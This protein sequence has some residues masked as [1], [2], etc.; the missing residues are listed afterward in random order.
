ML[1][2]PGA[3]AQASLARKGATARDPA[4]RAEVKAAA[5]ALRADHDALRPALD[6]LGARVIGDV[7]LVANA[8]LVRVD[9][10]AL[11]A[12]RKLPGVAR[13]EVPTRV[14]RALA[15]AVPLIGAP[16]VWVSAGDT[17]HT[18]A[19]VRVGV[20]DSG[21]DYYHASLGGSGDPADYAADDATIVEAGTFP[22]AR[23]VGGV[24]LA[25][26]DYDADGLDGSPTPAP[27][28]DPLDCDGH[29]TLVA[30]AAAGGGVLATGLGYAGPWTMSLVPDDFAVSP[31][32][33]P[34]A[35]LFAIRIFGCLGS[36]D[37]VV[38][39]LEVAVDPDGDLDPVDR[40]DVVNLSFGSEF[41]VASDAERAAIAALD[42]AGAVVV[43]SAGNSDSATFST[44]YPSVEPTVLSVGATLKEGVDA[45]YAAI[46]VTA[47]AAVAGRYALGEPDQIP[48]FADLGDATMKIVAGEPILGCDAFTNAR[49]LDG[50]LVIVHRGTCTFDTKAANAQAAGAVGV[51]IVDTFYDDAPPSLGGSHPIPIAGF[52]LADGEALIA[53]SPVDVTVSGE[54]EIKLVYGPDYVVNL[55]ARGPT[56]GNAALKPDV[57]APGWQIV[58]ASV[59]TGTDADVVSGTS[60]AAPLVAGGAALLREA[61]PELDPAGVRRA[62]T[63]TAH[64]AIGPQGIPFPSHA[65]GAGRVQLGEAVGASLTA[66]SDA[67]DAI[68]VSFGM[69]RA[70]AATSERRAVRVANASAAAVTLDLALEPALDWPG[71]TVTLDPASVEVPAGGSATFD[72]VLAV[73]P[74]A[75][76]PAPA[77]A[78]Y[79]KP[80]GVI[81]FGSQQISVPTIL[82]AASSGRVVGTPRDGAHNAVVVPYYAA[83]RAASEREVGAVA[84][85]V[86]AAGEGAVTLAL[87]GAAAHHDD[88]LSVL[89]L[90]TEASSWAADDPSGPDGAYDLVA[91]GAYGDPENRRVFFGV[92]AAGD[93]VSPALG[94]V[95]VVGVEVDTDGDEEA[96]YLVLAES[97]DT[98]EAADPLYTVNRGAPYARV[99]DLATGKLSRAFRPLNSALAA[100]PGGEFLAPPTGQVDGDTATWETGVYFNRV[101]V[102]P[103]ALDDLGLGAG[104]GALS[105][106]A[107]SRVSR[108]PFL[109][110]RPLVAPT[111]T[112]DWVA[113]DA[114]AP[115]VRLGPAC[116]AATQLCPGGAGA[117][118]VELTG[119]GATA[120]K[121]LVFHHMNGAAPRWEV[122]D[123]AAEALGSDLSVA[124]SGE[125]SVAPGVAATATFT[126]GNGAGVAREAV[127]VTVTAAGGELGSVQ[128]SQG[129]CAVGVCELGALAPGASATVVVTATR[130]DAGEIALTA[131]AASAS[132]CEL[133][134]GDESAT[135]SVTVAGASV[136][137]DADT[138]STADT[139]GGGATKKSDG[140]CAA[141]EGAPGAL[142]AWLALA[143]LAARAATW[144]RRGGA[145]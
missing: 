110:D 6:R 86:D 20:L 7:V 29:G 89:E 52:R 115:A 61:R 47:P 130:A 65:A 44:Y 3:I 97:F 139:G 71:V 51:L 32:V 79:E 28:D 143:A 8:L 120:P 112:T 124:A 12:L 90:G 135:L 40:L 31:G 82:F 133:A 11:P 136:E 104:E 5:T 100:V 117:V 99:V 22:T 73:D 125:T 26:D 142:F 88:A 18:G 144:R 131:A 127:T 38:P 103:V 121:L 91:T 102:L 81:T 17:A 119:D 92:A 2:S 49:K 42:A 138:I 54:L 53:A 67:G 41:G 80:S 57:V 116:H 140:G 33:A 76:P 109:V 56:A 63:S 4:W 129:T 55:S 83:A 75:L 105:Y 95:S 15:E 74:A 14:S 45:W 72:V 70:S 19:G 94:F 10:S 84:G 141:G 30:G 134:A 58:S 107:V 48:S 98:P 16:A 50:N 101:V 13:L 111:D 46:E 123:L 64:A 132:D 59:G 37:L 9:A 77:Y 25:G 60:I 113:F 126:V 21:I 27:D 69:V 1:E 137:D 87:D 43:A 108:Y 122:V 35:E 24:D 34:E 23:V 68:G 39:A 36:T 106:R 145:V 118:D 128:P 114:L 93:W 85:C 96:D 62:L 78:A 66:W